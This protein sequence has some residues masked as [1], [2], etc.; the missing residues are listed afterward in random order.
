L[1][2]PLFPSSSLSSLSLFH[3]LFH[4]HAPNSQ[5]TTHS[6]YFLTL[7]AYQLP[8]EGNNFSILV[9]IIS[10][11][12]ATVQNTVNQIKVYWRKYKVTPFAT[13]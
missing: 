2:S 3:S 8:L 1:L 11:A 6:L 4:V 10:L 5:I 9:I 12:P 13:R 7:T